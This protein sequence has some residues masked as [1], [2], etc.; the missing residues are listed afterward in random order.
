MDTNH[1]IE[2]EPTLVPTVGQTDVVDVHS[3]AWLQFAPE[4]RCK[5]L[6]RDDSSGLSCVLFN[7]APGRANAA[8]CAHRAGVHVRA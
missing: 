3:I 2:A 6:Y 8:P 7:F 1:S 4:V 5:V